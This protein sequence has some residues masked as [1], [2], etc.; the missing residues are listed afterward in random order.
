[1]C[2]TKTK[3]R[4]RLLKK[5]YLNTGRGILHIHTYV[6]KKKNTYFQKFANGDCYWLDRAYSTHTE[7]I[8]IINREEALVQ[9]YMIEMY[10]HVQQFK[11]LLGIF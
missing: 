9:I 1:M 4:V 11:Y 8:Y 5:N 2:K 7:Y 3:K 6:G 10:V